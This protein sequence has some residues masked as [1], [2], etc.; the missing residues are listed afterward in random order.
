MRSRDSIPVFVLSYG[1]VLAA[2][3]WKAV[4]PRYRQFVWLIQAT[5]I[6]F[7]VAL[8]VEFLLPFNSP[9]VLY[10]NSLCMLLLLWDSVFLALTPK[11][12]PQ[13]PARSIV[14]VL[15]WILCSDRQEK[16]RAEH[17]PKESAE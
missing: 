7:A 3:S 5:L 4:C 12:S 13:T 17:C 10:G 1:S 15:V 11:S 6:P 9:D 2:A 8:G 14:A 16:K